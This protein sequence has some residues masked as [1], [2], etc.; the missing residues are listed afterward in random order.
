CV[1]C[2]TGER[3]LSK[4]FNDE[5]MRENRLLAPEQLDA[6]GLI[7]HKDADTPE[8]V[9]VRR[10]QS[11]REALDLITGHDISQLPVTDGGRNVGAVTEETLMARVIE[12]PATLD[13]PVAALM[14]PPFPEV[15]TSSALDDVARLLTRRNPAVV[16][17]QDGALVGIIT[18]YDMVRQLT[19]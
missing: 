5:W 2:D 19:G 4:V 14:D 7:R 13:T 8:I 15:E 1:L 11:V 6:G 3:Y 17:R 10:D 18:R 16:V 12:D 9:V